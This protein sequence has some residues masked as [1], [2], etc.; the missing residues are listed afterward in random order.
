MNRIERIPHI[1]ATSERLLLR[2]ARYED[3]EALIVSWC[4]PEMSRWTPHRDD[5][6][7]FVRQ[8]ARP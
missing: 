6:P 2:R 1:F 4:D 5:R 8:M 3:L 7:G